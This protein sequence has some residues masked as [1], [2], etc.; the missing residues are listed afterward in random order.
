MIK[1]LLLAGAGGGV[2]ATLRYVV[3]LLFRNAAMPYPTLLINILGSFILGIILAISLKNNDLME[4]TKIFL[5]TGVCGGFTTFSAFSAE[6]LQLIET[7]KI[8]VAMLYI[9]LSV[10]GGITALWLGIKIIN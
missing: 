4:G 5:A 1:H 10:V 7:G 6:N 8:W 2:G 9:A 3:Y